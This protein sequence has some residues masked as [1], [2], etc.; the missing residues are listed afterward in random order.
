MNKRNIRSPRSSRE[1]RKVYFFS[2]AHLGIGPA[3][4]DR[5]KE[6]R[7]IQ[8]LTFVQQDAEQVFIVGDL[9]DFWFEYRSVVPKGYVRLLGALAHLTDSG[10]NVTFIA[11]NHDFWHKDYFARELGIEV[12]LDPVERIIGGKRFYIHHGDGLIK[13]DRGYRFLKRVLRNRFNIWLF[14]LVHP[15]LAGAIARWSSG[16]SREYTSSRAYE[17]QDMTDFAA[18]KIREGFDFVVMGHHHHAARKQLDGGVYM[19]L[20]DWMKENTYGVFDGH[21]LA[22]K[23][24]KA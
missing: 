20:G 9:F 22:L 4:E 18:S 7:I 13:D 3:A 19:N 10:V 8:F 6:Q 2:D 5:A 15:D 11:G 17:D 1:K 21:T 12:S 14:S 24:W 16:T 23:T